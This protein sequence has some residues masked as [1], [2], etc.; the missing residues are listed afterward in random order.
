MYFPI[1]MTGYDD[2]P[3]ENHGL[4]YTLYTVCKKNITSNIFD[5]ILRFCFSIERT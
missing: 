4:L 5:V 1:D 2:L 3:S